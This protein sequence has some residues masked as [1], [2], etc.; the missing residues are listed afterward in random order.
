MKVNYS[1]TDLYQPVKTL[2]ESMG[3]AVKAEVLNVDLMAVRGEDIVCVELKMKLNLEVILQA[4]DRQKIVENAYLAVPSWGL[5]KSTKRMQAIEHLLKRLEI[6]FIEVSVQGNEWVAHI[7]S[8]AVCFDRSKSMARAKKKQLALKKEFQRRHGD[9][10]V[11]GST[12]TKRMT[13]YKQDAIAFALLLE[14]GYEQMK[15]ISLA[16]ELLKGKNQILQKNYYGWFSRHKVGHYKLTDEG[17][18][19][20][21][22]LS[23]EQKNAYLERVSH[24]RNGISV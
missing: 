8:D 10:N 6:G 4:V 17:I 18:H 14:L 23:E 20:V 19:F 3:F 1:E 12:R 13:A 5:P 9:D 22:Q 11:G 7:L 16:A 24:Y 2:F 15:H 21:A